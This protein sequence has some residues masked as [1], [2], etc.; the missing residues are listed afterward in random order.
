MRRAA[1][2]AE[3]MRSTNHAEIIRKL[4]HVAGKIS[5]SAAGQRKSAGDIQ[6][7]LA[8]SI[9]AV[10]F[11][12]EFGEIKVRWRIREHVRPQ[13][14]QAKRIDRRITDQVGAADG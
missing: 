4:K 6:V 11:R 9:T 14:R 2:E 12:T 1:A 8:R 7:R 3:L 13:E 5:A 10:N